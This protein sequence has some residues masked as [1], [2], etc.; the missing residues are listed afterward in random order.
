MDTEGMTV[1]NLIGTNFFDSY[2]GV[3]SMSEAN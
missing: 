1:R 2:L 3:H